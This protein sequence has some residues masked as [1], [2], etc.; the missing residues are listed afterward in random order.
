MTAT[1]PPAHRLSCLHRNIIVL[2]IALTLLALP[3]KSATAADSDDTSIVMAVEFN[4]H[5]ACAHVARHKGWYEDEGIHVR[6]YDSYVTGMAL[7]AGLMRGDVDAAYICLIPAINV[8]AN[9]HVP[10]KIVAGTHKYGYAMVVDPDLIGSP[11]DLQKPGIRIGCSREG[12]P[13]DVILHKII[14]TYSL[15]EL[16]LAGNIRRMNPPK[17]LIAL[18]TGQIDAAVVPEQYPRMAELLGFKILV[19]AQDLWPDMPGSV[20]LV[21]GKL[22]KDHPEIVQKLVKVTDKA[23]T[24]INRHPKEACEIIASQ[25]NKTESSIFPEKVAKLNSRFMVTPEVVNASLTKGLEYSTD[26]R[27]SDIE[28]TI[29]YM[30]KLGYIPEGFAPE[31]ILDLRWLSQ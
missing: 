28:T 19:Q 23:T 27:P 18:K 26:I 4:A 21:T 10:L 5:A 6:S 22:I 2:L 15:D 1:T 8:F 7:A 31:K 3:Q 9:G 12:S 16:S 30:V 11:Q 20:L 25:L 13:V 14:E 29:E 17:Q 24:W